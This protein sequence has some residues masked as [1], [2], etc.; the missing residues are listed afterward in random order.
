[1]KGSKSGLED[2]VAK[3]FFL[4]FKRG[5][6]TAFG[7]LPDWRELLTIAMSIDEQLCGTHP[8]S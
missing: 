5:L 6:I 7:K 3:R 2:V 8:N 1:M 4:L